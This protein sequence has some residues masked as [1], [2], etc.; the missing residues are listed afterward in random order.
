MCLPKIRFVEPEP[1]KGLVVP[2]P[3][4]RHRTNIPIPK[5]SLGYIVPPIRSKKTSV[6]STLDAF[7]DGR[8]P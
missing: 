4:A 3:A 1:S 2:A 6:A 5:V 7:P 8:F